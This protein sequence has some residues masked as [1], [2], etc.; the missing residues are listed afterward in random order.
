M[1]RKKKI[2]LLLLKKMVNILSNHV[3]LFEIHLIKLFSCQRVSFLTQPKIILT[4]TEETLEP[5]QMQSVAAKD[6][7]TFFLLQLYIM[8]LYYLIFFFP[9]TWTVPR[10]LFILF[11]SVMEDIAWIHVLPVSKYVCFVRDNFFLNCSQDR[12]E[13][14]EKQAEENE[15]EEKEKGAA[16]NAKCF[17]WRIKERFG[18][19]ELNRFSILVWFLQV[20]LVGS[21]SRQR[22]FYFRGGKTNIEPERV[23]KGTYVSSIDSHA[24]WIVC[25]S[26]SYRRKKEGHQITHFI[27]QRSDYPV[28]RHFPKF[29]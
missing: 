25:C 4:A 1:Q 12:K 24:F 9:V 16:E 20:K 10:G 19:P 6:Y 13:E 27:E 8:S 18:H 3:L 17:R 14:K 7:G 2:T 28:T 15:K 11:F 23:R 22:W 29:C 5:E 26:S 21:Q